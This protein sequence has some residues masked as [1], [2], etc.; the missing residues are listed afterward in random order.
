MFVSSKNKFWFWHGLPLL[1]IFALMVVGTSQFCEAATQQNLSCNIACGAVSGKSSC[2]DSE[3]AAQSNQ[4]SLC[5]VSP[6]P[7]TLLAKKIEVPKQGS[8]NII[9]HEVRPVF[10][11]NKNSYMNT[12]ADFYSPPPVYLTKKSLLC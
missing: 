11:S 1:I 8:F 6:K 12:V 9:T 4:Q 2:H 10:F 5:H 3:H 7:L